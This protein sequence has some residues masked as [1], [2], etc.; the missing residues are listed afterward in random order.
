MMKNRDR[1]GEKRKEIV[2]KVY[3]SPASRPAGAHPSKQAETKRLVGV[4]C[5]DFFPLKQLKSGKKKQKKKR[6]DE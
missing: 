6:R 1:T 5:G 3:E 2:Q 4:R